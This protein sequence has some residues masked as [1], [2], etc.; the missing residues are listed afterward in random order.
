MTEQQVLIDWIHRVEFKLDENGTYVETKRLASL[1]TEMYFEKYLVRNNALKLPERLSFGWMY[2][3]KSKYSRD[4]VWFKLSEGGVNGDVNRQ[5]IEMISSANRVDQFFLVESEV[6]ILEECIDVQWKV[7]ELIVKG[8]GT[9][10]PDLSEQAKAYQK[11]IT[12]GVIAEL[13]LRSSLAVDKKISGWL[14]SESLSGLKRLFSQRCLMNFSKLYLSDIDAVGL[15]EDGSIEVLEFKRKDPANGVRYVAI[16][17]YNELSGVELYI[18]RVYAFKCMDST[19]KVEFSNSSRWSASKSPSFGLD[20]SHAKN[21]ELCCR[22]GIKYRYIIWN[23]NKTEPGEL[24]THCWSPK[25]PLNIFV[26]DVILS[27]FDGLSLTYGDDSGSYTEETRFQVMI[28]VV[29][30]NSISIPS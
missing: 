16:P 12:D 29:S 8:D 6:S 27:S 2:R 3:N 9:L 14:S 1:V 26:M 17:R 25:V 10:L 7:T 18:S 28:P 4:R 5:F 15:G 30:F 19:F 11:Q 23:S 13:S 22:A 24:L 20:I 21:V